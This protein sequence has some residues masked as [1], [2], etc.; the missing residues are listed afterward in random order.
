MSYSKTIPF[1]EFDIKADLG[2]PEWYE[3][4]MDPTYEQITNLTKHCQTWHWVNYIRA[5][6]TDWRGM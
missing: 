2:S 5:L 4:P 1:V 3:A 6:N